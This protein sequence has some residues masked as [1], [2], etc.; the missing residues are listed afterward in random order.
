MLMQL[1][2]HDY[3]PEPSQ[4]ERSLTNM[5][6]LAELLQQASRQYKHPQQLLK[7]FTEQCQTES[8]Q[9]AAQ[10]RLESDANLIRIITQHGSK[11]LE[12]PIVFIPFASAF[13]DPVRFGQTLNNYFEYHD[14]DTYQAKC[15][16]G[17][18][19]EAINLATAEG[20]A[21]NIRLLY[22]A[23]TRAAY[24]CYLGVAPFKNSEKSPLGLTLK[25][26]NTNHWQQ[27]LQQLADSSH[28]SSALIEISD[29][30][31]TLPRTA[32]TNSHEQASI[33]KLD[34]PI[35]VRWALSSFSSLMRDTYSARQEHK[36]HS[37][38]HSEESKK[39]SIDHSLRFSL[40][41]GADTG[42]LLHD[43]LEHTNFT[44][45][46]DWPIDSPLRRFGG[47]PE[48]EQIELTQWLQ[49][50]LNT[51][52][53]LIA[54]EK[55]AIKL[56]DLSWSQTLRESEFYFPLH[57]M[58]VKS[59]M[60][61]L[62][63]HRGN[64][65]P[66]NLPEQAHLF[67]MMRGFI[68][69]IFEHNGRFYV[70]DYKSTHLGDQFEDYHWQALKEN[71]QHH[72]YDLQ[73]LIYSLALHRYLS[74]RIPHYDPSLHFG[75]VY[76]LYLRGMSTQNEAHY[77]IYHTAIELS[78]LENLDKIFQGEAVQESVI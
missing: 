44:S 41:K 64:K 10:L 59:L 26:S 70:V 8:Q 5:I 72:Y 56:S 35:D 52:L 30:T 40:R 12:Y 78:L 48:A 11:G 29:S 18:S 57:D 3:Q 34:Y 77:G 73:Y 33:S 66:I 61:C 2:G 21:E 9:E 50:C 6:H 39:T 14:P 55:Q 20:E 49:D 36:D 69:L 68:D 23:I 67:G 19:D 74:S 54:P 27:T 46:P 32:P 75:G 42:N 38:D 15:Q 53:P 31:P 76:Y 71:N 24:R 43:I 45:E 47:L 58:Q 63:A 7:W 16:V 51:P 65:Q 13:K 4:H 28:N 62:Q 17:Q 22:V 37:D 25:L 60:T 1:I